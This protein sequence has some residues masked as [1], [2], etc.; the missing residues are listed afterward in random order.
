MFVNK[1]LLPIS[2]NYVQLILLVAEATCGQQLDKKFGR[3]ETCAVK[4]KLN[5]L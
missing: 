3:T 2:K 4:R 5:K 1:I